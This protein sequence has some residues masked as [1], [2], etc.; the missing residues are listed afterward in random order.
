MADHEV[1]LR[2]PTFPR[3]AARLR[4]ITPAYQHCLPDASASTDGMVAKFS[5]L[6]RSYAGPRT[7]EIVPS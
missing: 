1:S 7:P 6:G 4:L 2:A 5:G 3:A